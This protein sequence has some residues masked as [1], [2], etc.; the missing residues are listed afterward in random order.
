MQISLIWIFMGTMKFNGTCATQT[1]ERW[2]LINP[3][4]K[5]PANAYCDVYVALERGE[6]CNI[7]QLQRCSLKAR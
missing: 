1:A 7:H 2:H 3:T 5:D 4:A 6:I